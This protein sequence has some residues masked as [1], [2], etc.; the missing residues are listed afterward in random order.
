M[1]VG[2]RAGCF[3]AH[4]GM[5]HLLQVGR[6]EAEQFA[7][8]IALGDKRGTP[9][10]VRASLGLHSTR[11]DVDTLIE[12]LHAIA[13]GRYQRVYDQDSH[14]GEFLPRGWAPTF[15]DLFAVGSST[16]TRISDDAWREAV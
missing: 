3:C 10:A 16:A 6:D 12:A 13:A 15:D 14:S 1:A 5:L 9:G 7:T 8:R 2:V 4:P 11:E